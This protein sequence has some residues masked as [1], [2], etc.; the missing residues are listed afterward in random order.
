MSWLGRGLAAARHCRDLTAAAAAAAA[1]REPVAASKLVQSSRAAVLYARR[2]TG[3]QRAVQRCVAEGAGPA[4]RAR[5]YVLSSVIHTLQPPPRRSASGGVNLVAVNGSRSCSRCAPI[6]IPRCDPRHWQS[7][8][9]RGETRTAS[10]KRRLH[11]NRGAERWEHAW[12]CAWVCMRRRTAVAGRGAVRPGACVRARVYVC[13][14]VSHRA[15]DSLAGGDSPPRAPS[16]Q[17]L[18]RTRSARPLTT[19]R[20]RD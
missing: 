8:R 12:P 6:R 2:W 15:G 5:R 10:H 9:A 4:R 17:G 13:V 18:R 16:L 7:P 11:D 19:P 14:S 1:R 20:P 3:G